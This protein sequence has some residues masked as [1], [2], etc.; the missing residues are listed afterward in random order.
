MF[1][2]VGGGISGLSNAYHLYKRF[3]HSTI[4]IIESTSRLGGTLK[5]TNLEGSICEEGPRSIRNSKYCYELFKMID[6]VGLSGEMVAGT[7]LPSVFIYYGGKLRLVPQNLNYEGLMNFHR[8]HPGMVYHAA[9][10]FMKY[11]YKG[12]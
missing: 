1:I 12:S 4:T 9:K 10:F 6:E 5:S 2:V 3:P 11:Y 7:T 8:D